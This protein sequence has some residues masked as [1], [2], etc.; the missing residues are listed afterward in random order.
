MTHARKK[1]WKRFLMLRTYPAIVVLVFMGIC[2]TIGAFQSIDLVR[3]AAK[4]AAFITEFG[5]LALMEGGFLQ[6]LQ[7][8]VRASIVLLA[9]LGFKTAESEL[10]SRWR[11]YRRDT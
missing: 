7:I 2:G 3:L 5:W 1:S 11:E 10:V 4:N 8:M 6:A 9:Y